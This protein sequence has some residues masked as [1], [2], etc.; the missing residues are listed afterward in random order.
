MFCFI[1]NQYVCQQVKQ[2]VVYSYNRVLLC[3]KNS[4]SCRHKEAKHKEYILYDA[5]YMK[6]KIQA[7][8]IYS[9][10][11]KNENSRCL[12]NMSKE[13]WD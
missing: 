11:E 9:L 2:T 10:K 7:K 6:F 3:K 12:E 1:H 4:D 5:I 13:H 8:V